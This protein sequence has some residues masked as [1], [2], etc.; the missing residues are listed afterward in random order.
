MISSP[1]R[2]SIA[3]CRMKTPAVHDEV[4]TACLRPSQAGQFALEL[5][6]LRPQDETARVQ[7]A[8][9]GFADF[10]VDERL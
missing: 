6:A 4:S 5:L 3:R 2:S 1:G 7:H 10:R 8:E 9:H